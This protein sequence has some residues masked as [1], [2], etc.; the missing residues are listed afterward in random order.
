MLITERLIEDVDLTASETELNSSI[1]SSIASQTSS[2]VKK[3]WVTL[4]F[5]KLQF[6]NNCGLYQ[7]MRIIHKLK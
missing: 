1:T 6:L 4:N 2:L 5:S 3:G 7:S